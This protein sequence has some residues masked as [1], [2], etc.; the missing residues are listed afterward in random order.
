MVVLA[1]ALI[2][3]PGYLLIDELSLGLASVVWSAG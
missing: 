2:S 3:Q 1:Q